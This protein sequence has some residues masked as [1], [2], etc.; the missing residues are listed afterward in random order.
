MPNMRTPDPP[1]N[2][3]VSPFVDASPEFERRNESQ[4]Y[5]EDDDIRDA[6]VGNSPTRD[7]F[8]S[9]VKRW[10][11]VPSPS[12]SDVEIERMRSEVSANRA[13]VA[14]LERRVQS[15]ERERDDA[16]EAA[17]AR[18]RAMNERAKK[19]QEQNLKRERE[20][21]ARELDLEARE[22][23]VA[24]AE[25]ERASAKRRETAV[26]DREERLRMDMDELDARDERLTEGILELE[27]EGEALRREAA[28][29]ERRRADIANELTDREV[30]VIKR[31]ESVAVREREMRV[32]EGH[33]NTLKER[34]VDEEARLTRAIERAD[35]AESREADVARRIRELDGDEQRARVSIR[36]AQ[37]DLAR[38]VDAKTHTLRE[39]ESLKRDVDAARN[40]V[41][42]LEAEKARLFRII[43]DMRTELDDRE[44]QTVDAAEFAAN[45]CESIAAAWDEVEITR[46]ALERQEQMIEETAARLEHNIQAYERDST[47]FREREE[48]YE[49]KVRDLVEQEDFLRKIARENEDRSRDLAARDT[50]LAER[51]RRLE[52]GEAEITEWR[53]KI[54][55][56]MA[57]ETFIR[58]NVEAIETAQ[59]QLADLSARERD[60]EAKEAQL[61]AREEAVAQQLSA[62]AEAE[63]ILSEEKAKLELKMLEV[64][65]KMTAVELEREVTTLR[66][67]LERTK[68]AANAAMA[69]ADMERRRR[70]EMAGSSGEDA[71]ASETKRTRE[72]IEN[73]T[74]ELRRANELLD[75]RESELM[76]REN[77]LA[78]E[79]DLLEREMVRFE[80]LRRCVDD[81]ARQMQFSGG[82]SSVDEDVDDFMTSERA[83]VMEIRAEAE[84]LR[85]TAR[86]HLEAA[87]EASRAA[88]TINDA[89]AASEKEGMAIVRRVSNIVASALSVA[90]AKGDEL[91]RAASQGV[92]RKMDMLDA[93][94]EYVA[95]AKADLDRRDASLRAS[96][97]EANSRR[98]ADTVENA[99]ELSSRARASQLRKE[100]DVASAKLRESL[101]Q[102]VSALE[103][104]AGVCAPGAHLA[105]RAS[106]DSLR[107]RSDHLSRPP[108]EDDAAALSSTLD[109]L[110]REIRRASTWFEELR[111]AVRAR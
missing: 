30:D 56:Y 50:A 7:V 20:F 14:E 58:E 1:P 110:E 107:A 41:E 6:I 52:S 73:E 111:V 67:E 10:S 3:P 99:Q 47:A 87:M 74:A 18:E 4:D 84:Q 57:K 70:E 33:L 65:P 12:R 101:A 51:L 108:V 39:T 94:L 36:E 89:C 92:D 46:Q 53:P 77:A 24:R 79:F 32:V 60:I 90:R 102:G 44:R 34:A 75:L 54:A 38:C 27:R 40:A 19:M 64:A 88:H 43:A 97:F 71:H 5:F 66:A 23:E 55:A 9:P 17:S 85:R 29:L 72:A 59:T 25:A 22:R 76:S 93:Q 8:R 15:A 109:A 11:D 78:D 61:E 45:E 100:V 95:K 105:L 16:R 63:V 31:E 28:A 68:A 96:S 98:R 106:L 83:A 103:R 80:D 69:N 62:V 37:S 81:R 13:Y 42:T 35:A 82:M 26:S 104:A 2:G 91:R 86:E 48:L 21:A 49:R